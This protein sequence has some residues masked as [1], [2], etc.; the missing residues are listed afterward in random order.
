M[1]GRAGQGAILAALDMRSRVRAKFSESDREFMRHAIRLARRGTGTA[2]PNPM[3][4]AVLVKTGEIIGKGWHRRAGGPHAEIA[5]ITDARKNGRNPRGATLYVTLEPCSTYGRTPPCTEAIRVAG[6]SRLVVSATDPNPQH[7]GRGCRLLKKCGVS[8]DTG[9][10]S[11]ETEELNEAFNYWIVRQLPFVTVKSAMTL[12]GKIATASGQSKWITGEKARAVGMKLR[13]R[14]DAVLVGINTILTDDPS[15]TIRQLGPGK[16]VVQSKGRRLRRIV[17][18]S[19]ARTPMSAKVV[20][21]GQSD[22]TTIVVTR[23]ALKQRVAMLAERT[24]VWIAPSENGRV[25]LNWL[26]AKLGAESVISMIV[27]GGGEVNAS[28]F[29]EKLVKRVAFFYAPKVFG[30]VRARRAVGGSGMDSVKETLNLIQVEWR[31]V[32]ID[33]FLTALVE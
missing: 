18:D 16:R 20:S 23:R 5:A 29:S 3:V 27:E 9:L 31:R 28:F 13:E 24:N 33:L 2:S 21:D 25:D 30:G 10:Y 17:L 8:I 12:D 22:L 7:A 6:I 1:C 15:L 26:L 19:R 14:S 11:E 4:G 32:G